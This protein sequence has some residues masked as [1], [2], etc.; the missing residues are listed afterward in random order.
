MA[1][2]NDAISD[3]W[4]EVPDDNFSV[5]S[6][7]TS[8]D[9]IEVT[10]GAGAHS[11]MPNPTIDSPIAT[12]SERF[13]LLAIDS[14]AKGKEKAAENNGGLDPGAAAAPHHGL[15]KFVTSASP[16]RTDAHHLADNL[17]VDM[18][19]TFLHKVSTSLIKLIGEIVGILHFGGHRHL[20]DG[21]RDI[22]QGIHNVCDCLRRHLRT[23]GPIMEGYSKHWD[24]EQVT[25]D[26]PL[27]PCLYE[28]MTDLKIELLGLQA[29]LQSQMHCSSSSTYSAS[30]ALQ[31]LVG[32]RNSLREFNDQV[33]GFIPIMQADFEEFHTANLPIVGDPAGSISPCRESL[34]H[35]G[36]T[37]PAA[38]VSLLKRELYGLKDQISACLAT[39]RG[40]LN[41]RP[42]INERTILTHLEGSYLKVKS[43]LDVLL[44]N[45]AS[46][47]IEHGL[48]GGM[49][50]PEFCRLNSDTIRSLN[51]QLKDVTE[52][53]R[54]EESRISALKYVNDPDSLLADEKL[55]VR[56]SDLDALRSI[57]EVLASLFHIKKGHSLADRLENL[58]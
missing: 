38:A 3:D 40:F 27:D 6:L 39:L 14:K 43:T 52:N 58:L 48:S 22:R 7:P 56:A 54:E 47:W 25:V 5:V 36:G 37:R 50:Y 19:P 57:E 34:Q 28:W 4:E 9:A 13:A 12:V 53:M 41:N 45:H 49:T 23:L 17:D 30:S 26:L 55:E 10:G 8:E 29:L 20:Q 44:S 33:S 15:D 11:D 1:A 24:P 16:H 2:K 46:E 18:D 32:Y 35:V 51:L 31:D 21:T 42:Y